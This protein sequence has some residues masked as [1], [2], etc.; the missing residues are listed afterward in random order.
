MSC[1]CFTADNLLKRVKA[2]ESIAG[3]MEPCPVSMAIG[4][5]LSNFWS[6]RDKAVFRQRLNSLG[7]DKSNQE[8]NQVEEDL[9]LIVHT[10]MLQMAMNAYVRQLAIAANHQPGEGEPMQPD[11]GISSPANLDPQDK[12]I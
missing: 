9:D 4:N 7:D 2:I 3:N 5:L 6:Q 10:A 1:L 8:D 11:S 12:Y